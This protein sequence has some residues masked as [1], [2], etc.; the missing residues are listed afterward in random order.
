MD[1]V[2]GYRATLEKMDW[3]GRL[4]GGEQRRHRLQGTMSP[5]RPPDIAISHSS[6][7]AASRRFPGFDCEAISCPRA[8]TGKCH[9]KTLPVWNEKLGLWP[10][11]SQC[12]RD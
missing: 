1:P 3:V 10:G 8:R 2:P 12:G 4:G 6:Y 7:K 9:D 5:V 11:A